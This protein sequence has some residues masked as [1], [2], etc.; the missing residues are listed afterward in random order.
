MYRTLLS[1]ISR[2]G[3][4]IIPLFFHL[5]TRIVDTCTVHDLHSDPRTQS[6][7]FAPNYDASLLLFAFE[8]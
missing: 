1:P 3:F 7:Y 2:L 4:Y 6:T 5:H 8:T